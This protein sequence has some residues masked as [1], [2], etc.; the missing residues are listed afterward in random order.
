MEHESPQVGSLHCDTFLWL[1]RFSLD[2]G[3]RVKS[4]RHERWNGVYVPDCA[5]DPF[6]SPRVGK[7]E[8]SESKPCSSQKEDS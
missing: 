5:A 3:G 8:S 2:E 4:Q 7:R 1:T 6:E